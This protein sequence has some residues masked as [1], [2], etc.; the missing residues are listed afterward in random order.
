MIIKLK[1]Y[2]EDNI[3]VLTEL[4]NKAKQ[5]LDIISDN[6]VFEIVFASYYVNRVLRYR[7]MQDEA[8]V[9]RL[10]SIIQ[11]L[12]IVTDALDYK[13]LHKLHKTPECRNIDEWCRQRVMDI[14]GKDTKY[15]E[16]EKNLYM[17]RAQFALATIT[18]PMLLY[19]ICFQMELHS[20]GRLLLILLTV[21]CYTFF[22]YSTISIID[23]F[24]IVPLKTVKPKTITK[25]RQQWHDTMIENIGSRIGLKAYDDKLYTL[26][27]NQLLNLCEHFDKTYSIYG[28]STDIM[29]DNADE[30]L[31]FKLIGLNTRDSYR[32]LYQLSYMYQLVMCARLI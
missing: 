30:I 19:C 1:T 18:F 12:S 10:I 13:V 27:A 28:Y 15:V 23:I 24:G 32:K 20:I 17:Y 3:E 8:M 21:L 22:F 29:K 26:W 4:A 6:E 16:F 5:G 31:N 2:A 11:D 25:T 9:S 7:I 14:Y